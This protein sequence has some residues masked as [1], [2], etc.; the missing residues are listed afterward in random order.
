MFAK[1][2]KAVS[3]YF[4]QKMSKNMDDAQATR[5]CFSGCAHC[6]GTYPHIHGNVIDFCGVYCAESFV[7]A[8]HLAHTMR[9]SRRRRMATINPTIRC[10]L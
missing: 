6:G 8:M 2:I 9:E 1:V 3:E 10:K 7:Q 4:V 5:A